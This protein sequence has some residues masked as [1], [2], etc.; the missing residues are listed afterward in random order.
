MAQINA[1]CHEDR[2]SDV[3]S[4]YEGRLKMYSDT[5]DGQNT[6]LVVFDPTEMLKKAAITSADGGAFNAVYDMDIFTQYATK[7]NQ[8]GVLPKKPWGRLGYRGVSSG[9]LTAGIGVAEGQALGTAVEPVYKE[10]GLA[11]KEIEAVYDFSDR[12][13]AYDSIAD[14]VT[15]DANRDQ[16]NKAFYKVWNGDILHD[17]DTLAGY[18]YESID[19]II[20][21]YSEAAGCGQTS[22]DLDPWT[23]TVSGISRASATADP[24]AD[25]YV[26][27]NSG[28][29]RT[30]TIAHIDALRENC[31]PYWDRYENKCFVTGYDTWR[32]WSALEESKHRIEMTKYSFT[33]GDGIQTSEG[34]EGGF[35]LASWDGIPIIRDDDVQKDTISR[36]Y[37]EDLDNLWLAF[38]RPP[39][40]TEAD[41]TSQDVFAVGHVWRGVHYNMGETY[42]TKFKSQGKLR[43]LK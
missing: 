18:N 32:R 7:N 16:G 26:S 40:Y 10:V 6:Q 38:A 14:V 25:A 31:E 17:N 15:I 11:I 4:W 28:T 29:D 5:F 24:W 36:V 8:F 22:G 23:D 41:P 20:A 30:L 19:T 35:K 33:V 43:D 1:E 39:T 13:Y 37:L 42:C 12:M 9:G 3:M 27:H 21:S 2:Y 34:A